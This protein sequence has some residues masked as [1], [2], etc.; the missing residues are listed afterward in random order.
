VPIED[1]L[2]Y[3][4]RQVAAGKFVDIGELEWESSPDKALSALE[5]YD[6]VGL[7]DHF[8]ESMWAM[9][10]KFGFVPPDILPELNKATDEQNPG[11]LNEKDIAHLRSFL[12]GDIKIYDTIRHKALERLNGEQIFADMVHKGILTKLSTPF[13][14]DLGRPFLGSGWYEPETQRG[15]S[16]RWSGPESKALLHVPLR[17][18]TKRSLY[19]EFIK[20]KGIGSVEILVDGEKVDARTECFDNVWSMEAELP[21]LSADNE[22]LVTTI[23]LDCRRPSHPKERNDGDLRAL[24]LLLL[25][26]KVD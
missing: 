24:G 11:D 1:V 8:K 9:C 13:E 4:R 10:G 7:M 19:V 17:R 23:T 12:A 2:A 26:V 3:V 15:R 20:S 6:F 25:T 21:P 22:P 18:D 16:V 14:L 5:A